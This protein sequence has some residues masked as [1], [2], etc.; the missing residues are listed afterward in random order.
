M[1]V[2]KTHGRD[3]ECPNGGTICVFGR[4]HWILWI[5]VEIERFVTSLRAHRRW[6]SRTW[7]RI[8]DERRGTD[9]TGTLAAL[10]TV[11]RRWHLFLHI[12]DFN[13]PSPSFFFSIE[14]K[15]CCALIVMR[16]S[17]GSVRKSERRTSEEEVTLAETMHGSEG[18][19]HRQLTPDS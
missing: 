11:L 6:R 19:H 8:V 13:F 16:E 3:H 1:R 12:S 15:K 10:R 18:S 2:V 17:T 14:V 9:R 4:R 5:S 7:S